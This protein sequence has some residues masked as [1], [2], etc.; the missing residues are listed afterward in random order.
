M[1]Q[2][3]YAVALIGFFLTGCSDSNFEK[4]LAETLEKKPE[5]VFQVIEKNPDKFM[6]TVQAAAR[7]ARPPQ[8]GED[9]RKL[10]EE[11]FKNPKQPAVDES[12]IVGKKDAPVLIVEYS[13]LE[14]PFCSR[15]SQTVADVKKEYGDKV[16]VIFK[17]LPLPMHPQARPAALYYEAIAAKESQVKAYEWAKLVFQNQQQMRGNA[18]KLFDDMAKKAGLNV[19]KIKKTLSDKDFLNKANA[20]ISAD[21]DEARKFGIQGTPGF[22]INGVT[23]KGA[24]PL[25]AF[26]E[27]IDRHLQSKN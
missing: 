26:K 19:A 21:M 1:K 6:Q 12:R 17:H 22:V 3:T 27:I 16:K 14:C 4:K 2:F 9:P 10:Q 13:D 11:E 7:K 25:P 15:G 8:Q 5:L 24:Y 20:K 23:I 18:Q